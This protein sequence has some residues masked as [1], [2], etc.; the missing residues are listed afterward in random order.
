[1]SNAIQGKYV[2]GKHS[3]VGDSRRKWEDRVFAEKIRRE[4]WDPLVVGIVADGVGSADFGSR[5]AQL[6]I[7]TVVHSLE[8]SQGN[9]IPHLLETAIKAAN[10]AVYFSGCDYGA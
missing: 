10:S 1:M 9:D 6:S 7:D 2:L 4:G 5:G 3:V 8:L